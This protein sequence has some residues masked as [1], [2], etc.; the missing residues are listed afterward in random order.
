[1]KIEITG[2]N[3]LGIWIYTKGVDKHQKKCINENVNSFIFDR[4]EVAA[5]SMDLGLSDLKD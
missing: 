4:W 5:K 1:V 2:N 3:N